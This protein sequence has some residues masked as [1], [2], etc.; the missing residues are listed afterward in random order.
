MFRVIHPVDKSRPASAS[1]TS[2]SSHI[3]R[4]ERFHER[5]RVS[6]FENEACAV[7][8]IGADQVS[9]TLPGSP[10]VSSGAPFLWR[11]AGGQR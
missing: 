7:H 5:G 2:P 10:L 9:F 4:R 8:R 1:R 6:R 11:G 3:V